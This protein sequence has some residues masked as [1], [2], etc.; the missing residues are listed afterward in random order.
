MSAHGSDAARRALLLAWPAGHSLSPAM[1]DAAFRELGIAARYEAREVPPEGLAE[2]V[3]ELRGPGVLGANVTVPHKEAVLALLDGLEPEAAAIG[4]VNTIVRADGGLRGANTDGAG[5][6]RAL[7]QDAGFDPAGAEVLL[8]GAG[9][10]ARAVAHALL[11][12]GAARVGLHNRT[13]ER[14]AAL[15]A[16]FAERGELRVL[17]AG[18]LSGGLERAD[19]LVNTTSVGMARGGRDP[20]V[21]PLPAGLLPRRALVVDLVYRPAR[22]RLLREAEAAGL[23]TQNGLPMLVYQGAEAFERWTGRAAP[24]A[25]MRAAAEAA[26]RPS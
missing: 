14:A 15:A 3:A 20:D 23:P 11:G 26:L 22:T 16:A 6:L 17:E 2:A 19:L 5:F 7:R 24:V 4:A 21:S 1:H 9:G 12:A 25:V 13:P 8:L 18:E 10:A